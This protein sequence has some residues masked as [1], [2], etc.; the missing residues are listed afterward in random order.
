MKHSELLNRF[1]EELSRLSR[2]VEASVAM[3]HYDINKICEDVFCGVFRDLFGLE[4]LRNLN[5]D[6]KQNFPGIDLADDVNRIAI[7]VTSDKSL[8]KVKGSLKTIINH[9]LHEK[10]GRVIFYILSRKQSSYSTSGLDRICEDKIS[11]DPSSDIMDFTDLASKAA[12]VEPRILKQAL[13]TLGAYTRGCDVGLSEQDFDPPHEPP[14]TLSTNLLGVYFPKSLYIGELLPDVLAG[15]R[16]RDQRKAVGQYIR[17]IER[18]V[19]S[20][21][22]VNSNKLITFHNLE[23]EDWNNPFSF[24]VD[25]GSVEPIDSRDYYSIDENHERVFKSLLRFCLQQKL[26]RHRV[27]WKHLEHIFI[28]RPV[29]DSYNSRKIPWKGRKRATRTVFVRRFRRNQPDKILSTRHFAFSAAFLTVG[30]QW[31]MSITPD[32]FFS[33]DSD[34]QNYQKSGFSENLISGMKRLEKNRSVFDQFRFLCAWLKKLDD[35]DLFEMEASRQ[36]QL[37]FGEVLQLSGGRHLNEDLWAPLA[38]PLGK[39][40]EQRRLRLQ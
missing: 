38:A 31:Y 8:Q 18:S 24:L 23:D 28:F 34:Y 20:N 1:R 29:K 12:T 36:N 10:Y 35:D 26:Y 33:F 27:L 30:D 4:N 6:E 25:E 15:S 13:D 3:G 16:S 2:E 32:W 22:E 37:T 14:E 40:A 17:N 7:Q 5:E 21:Y 9:G 39:D 11:F 19:P